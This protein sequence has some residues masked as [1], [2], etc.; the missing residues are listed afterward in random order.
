MTT[1]D[2]FVARMREQLRLSDP[3]L[4][5][6]IGT[7]PRKMI[8][9][10]A[11]MM[12]ELSL[13]EYLIEYQYDIDSRT[14][15]SLDELVALF[16][17][18]RLPAHRATGEVTLERS[19]SFD[20]TISI[21]LGTQ[22]SDDSVPPVVVTT[23][24]PA[25]MLEGDSIIT[26][27]CRVVEGGSAGNITANAIKRTGSPISGIASYTNLTAFTGG[28][29]PESDDAL[30]S[31]FKRT[32]F[33]NLAG[34]EDQ[35]LGV[36]LENEN[37]TDANVLGPIER[38]REQIELV[39]N[40][41]THY[42]GTAE[43]GTTSTIQDTDAAWTVNGFVGFEVLTTGG[44]GSGQSRIISANTA[45]TI[46]VTL[47][48]TVTPDATTTFSVIEHSIEGSSTIVNAKYV[49]DPDA[50]P[51][52]VFL[53]TDIDSD[54][55]FNPLTTYHVTQTVN[56]DST[57]T[58]NIFSDAPDVVTEGIYELDFAY[59]PRASRNDPD[60]GITNRVDVWVDG[61]D[62]TEATEIARYDTA[63]LFNSTPGD[64]LDL[65]D[66]QRNETEDLPVANNIF[67]PLHFSP[68]VDASVNDSII[69]NGVTYYEGTDYFAV[70]KITSEGMAPQSLSGIEWVVTANGGNATQPPDQALFS[71][72]Y[73]YNAVPIQVQKSLQAWRQ[74]TQDVWVHAALP[75]LL[76]FHFVLILNE[77]ANSAQVK[78]DMIPL[79]RNHLASI[80]FAN[81]LQASDLLAIAHS[82]PGVDAVRFTRADEASGSPLRYGIQRVNSV[83]TVLDEDEFWDITYARVTDVFVDDDS[84]PKLNDIFLTIKA[85]NT[86]GGS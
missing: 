35:I 20:R 14:G 28:T 63:S 40:P 25:I 82:T 12:S 4:D 29:D 80:G 77:G 57:I 16:G 81:Q 66:W 10:V 64:P 44:T 11:E 30:R 49:Y 24:V 9:A 73:T 55:I 7:I 41:T 6:T 38:H 69:Y 31:R 26:V 65:N 5:T 54:D 22:F 3:D 33:R 86:W 83:G 70:N 50:Y 76:N 1:R 47:D 56:P 51:G 27:P 62:V 71:V 60:N 52:A 43:A 61:E 84:V 59:V 39:D 21:P 37:V 45:D 34:T 74:M 15:D 8:D 36:T 46:T 2:N 68:V 17:F 85:P 42:N 72:S 53:G 32:I 75:I 48:W 67:I 18:S 23:I 79:I 19:T 58:P 13:D 78:T